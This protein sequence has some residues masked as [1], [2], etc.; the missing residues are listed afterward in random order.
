MSGREDARDGDPRDG[1]AWARGPDG[2]RMWGRYG[3]AGLLAT[4][5]ERGVLLQH[6]AAWSHHGGSWGIPGGALHADEEPARGALREA[7]EET[8][9]PDDAL[10]PLFTRVLELGFWR[11]TTF[12]AEVVRPFEAS[13]VD[14][15]TAGVAW[16]QPER[17]TEL[18]LHP[19]FAESWPVLRELLEAAP[20]L[21][22]DAANVVGARPDGWWRDRAAAAGRLLERL[23]RLAERG[24]PAEPFGLDAQ[25]VWPRLLVVLEGAARPAAEGPGRPREGLAARRMEVRTA[26]GS[27]DDAIAAAVREQLS[28]TP[29]RTVLLATSDRGLRAR[30]EPAARTIGASRLHGLLPPPAP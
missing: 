2:T 18:E 1:D 8:G 26:P 23:A 14:S 6:R 19:A 27:G 5:P 24:M 9:T 22:V 15:E 7:G 21:V 17:V 11:Y 16:V 29:G 10:D 20:L 28:R 12:A 13:A 3:A 4:D 30:V 25:A